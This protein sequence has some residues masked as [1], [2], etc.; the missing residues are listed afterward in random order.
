VQPCALEISATVC[1]QF[2]NFTS[3]LSIADF[4]SFDISEGTLPYVKLVFGE[5]TVQTVA[6]G[7]QC[8]N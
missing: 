2:R 8:A 4:T 3:V 5:S 6:L 1:T 7:G